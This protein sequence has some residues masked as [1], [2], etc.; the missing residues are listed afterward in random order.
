MISIL[1]RCICLTMIFSLFGCCSF[2]QIF[3]E[4]FFITESM[5]TIKGFIKPKGDIRAPDEFYF[6]KSNE[7]PVEQL[8][9]TK[10]KIVVIS[11]YRYY[12]SILIN[13]VPSYAQTIVYGKAS[14]F[15][16]DKDFYIQSNDQL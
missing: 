4:G 13:E 1:I 16:R 14:L 12:R 15:L 3:Q 10:I 6:K 5:D 2:G 11:N 8:L 9:P 7:S